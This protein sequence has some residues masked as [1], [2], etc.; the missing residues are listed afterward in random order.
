MRKWIAVFLAA[1]LMAPTASAQIIG[2]PLFN[3]LRDPEPGDYTGIRTIAVI[4]AIGQNMTIVRRGFLTRDNPVDIRAWQFDEQ[5]VRATQH[6]FGTHYTMVDVPHDRATLAAIPAGRDRAL[7]EY[8]MA[9]PNDGVDAFMVVRQEDVR[10][11]QLGEPG[12]TVVRNNDGTAMWVNYAVSIIDAR[13][14]ETIGHSSSRMAFYAGTDPTYPG[15][16]IEDELF[17]GDDLTPTAGQM[18]ELHETYLGL[19]AYSYLETLRLLEL[20]VDLP[21]PGARQTVAQTAA[22]FAQI[23]T[24][25]AA[26]LI[27]DILEIQAPTLFSMTRTEVAVPHWNINAPVMQQMK[28][29]L[30]SRYNVLDADPRLVQ[31]VIAEANARGPLEDGETAEVIFPDPPVDA[32]IIVCG[33]PYPPPDETLAAFQLSGIGLFRRT[34]RFQHENLVF[35]HLVIGVID[36]RTLRYIQLS[37]TSAASSPNPTSAPFDPGAWFT[38]AAEMTPEKEGIVRS[39]IEPL[40]SDSIDTTLFN[41]GLTGGELA[42]LPPGW[43]VP[44]GFTGYA[45]AVPQRER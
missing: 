4:S 19:V 3:L 13:S 12:L 27:L 25:G 40:L 43:E 39:A 5:I 10:A 38:S 45:F 9:L 36:A 1:F 6:Y 16:V 31:T 7:R 22:D 15:I 18:E 21:P 30:S 42:L 20:G 44:P 35:V 14:Y 8:L 17:P 33:Y 2:P 32:Y 41:M 26:S 24:L 34:D 11:V 23:R 37:P 29:V 28:E